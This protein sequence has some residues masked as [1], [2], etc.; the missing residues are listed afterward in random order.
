MG[1]F[2]KRY[3]KEVAKKIFDYFKIGKTDHEAV[4]LGDFADKD[5]CHWLTF[6]HGIIQSSLKSKLID[7]K[8][9]ENYVNITMYI[10]GQRVDVAIIKDGCKSPHELLQ[11]VKKDVYDA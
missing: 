4:L 8:D 3:N 7:G 6:I 5:L 1:I 2:K 10:G 9:I 11:E